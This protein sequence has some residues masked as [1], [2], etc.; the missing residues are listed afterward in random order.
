[1][2]PHLSFTIFDRF[3]YKYD[4]LFSH[5]NMKIGTLEGHFVI[6]N[7]IFMYL[8]YRIIGGL[9]GIAFAPSVK[10]QRLKIP[11]RV[12]SKTEKLAPVASLVSV[13]LLR[14]RVGWLAQCQFK[15]T[16][17]GIMFI[18]GMVFQCTDTFKTGLSLDQL[19]QI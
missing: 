15:V 10:G 9:V 7:T 3:T 6:E 13:Q 19:Q 12:K 16:E 5:S 4:M 17:L 1:M 14:P 18:C 2:V 11:S 8:S